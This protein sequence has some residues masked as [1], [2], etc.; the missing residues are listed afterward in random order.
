[1]LIIFAPS[2]SVTFNNP[3]TWVA[4]HSFSYH[5]LPC[6]EI[7]IFTYNAFSVSL[8]VVGFLFSYIKT[9]T[10]SFSY[11]A[12]AEL[13]L[14]LF[15]ARKLHSAL[16]KAHEWKEDSEG[17]KQLKVAMILLFIF[18]IKWILFSDKMKNTWKKL[19]KFCQVFGRVLSYFCKF[20]KG[21][22]HH[23]NLDRC[24]DPLSLGRPKIL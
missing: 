23:S 18:L 13:H 17:A 4:S 9:G 2:C 14:P 3:R 21:H 19:S 10:A 24:Q 11:H 5:S 22:Q 8:W 12:V 20:Q 7:G 6:M 16:W 1:M 15:R